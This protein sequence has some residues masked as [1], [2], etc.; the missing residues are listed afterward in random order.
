M[1]PASISAIDALVCSARQL[2]TTQPAAPAPTKTKSY[3]S[4]EISIFLFR[5]ICVVAHTSGGLS[6]HRA[7]IIVD[8]VPPEPIRAATHDVA[9]CAVHVHELAVRTCSVN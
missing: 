4:S 6:H 8:N 2:A 1:S 3:S 5:A 7:L 9:R